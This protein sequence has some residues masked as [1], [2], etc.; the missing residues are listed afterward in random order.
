MQASTLE[1]V[2]VA[3]AESGRAKCPYDPTSVYAFV[4]SG[5]A[6]NHCFVFVFFSPSEAAL[7]ALT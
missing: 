5:T 2:K 6:K 1:V 7:T 4:Y 3:A